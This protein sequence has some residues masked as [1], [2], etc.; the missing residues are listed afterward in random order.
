[1]QPLP[2]PSLGSLALRCLAHISAALALSRFLSS[3]KQAALAFKF[4][5]RPPRSIARVLAC[6]SMHLQLVVLA[7]LCWSVLAMASVARVRSFADWPPRARLADCSRQHSFDIASVDKPRPPAVERECLFKFRRTRRSA[8]PAP[9]AEFVSARCVLAWLC[10]RLSGSQLTWRTRLRSLVDARR[11]QASPSMGAPRRASRSS[12]AAPRR[13]LFLWLGLGFVLLVC[14][15]FL[16]SA[17]RGDCRDCCSPSGTCAHAFRQR[18]GV[19]CGVI[20]RQTDGHERGR[21]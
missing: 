15:V 10:R 16:A 2:L 12:A 1:M 18:D 19:C 13:L 9:A 3:C 11:Q 6:D 5:W 17:V 7:W 20:N 8:P 14:V 4:L 21:D